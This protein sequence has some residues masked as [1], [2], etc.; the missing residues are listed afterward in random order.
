MR[1][2]KL[3]G[4]VS[5]ACFGAIYVSARAQR[6]VAVRRRLR[7]E[8]LEQARWESEGGANRTGPATPSV[9]TGQ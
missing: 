3:L 1:T 4:L 8:L 2:L 5:L 7:D 9:V 6:Q